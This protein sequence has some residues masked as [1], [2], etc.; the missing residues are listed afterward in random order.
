MA[1]VLCFGDSNTWGTVPGKSCRYDEN[2]RWPALLNSALA[3]EADV[4]E[5]GQQGRTLVHNNPFQ[6]DKNGQRYLKDCVE[7]YAPDLVLILL[8]TNDLK[9]RFALCVDDVAK[10]AAHLAEQ[11]QQYKS[12]S[13]RK[14]VKVLLIA[15]PAVYEVGAY[16]KMYAGAGAKSMQFAK[17]YA[18]YAQQIGCAFFDAGSVVTSCTEE[19][20]HWQKDQHQLLADALVPIV[21]DMLD[22]LG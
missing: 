2:E 8:G 15:P 19:G 21:Q 10:S 12:S 9:K 11:T 4:I 7:K 5:E 6:G 16:A 3:S 17:F 13:L 1:R 22:Q 20:I 18:L 14:S